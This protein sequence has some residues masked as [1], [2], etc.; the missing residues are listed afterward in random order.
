MDKKQLV[1]SFLLL[2]TATI[3]G[4]SYVAQSVV[5]SYL[6]AFSYSALKCAIGG[7]CLIPVCLLLYRQKGQKFKITKQE[8][9][10]GC[11][12]GI[13]LAIFCVLQQSGLATVE[14]GKASFIVA[15]YVILV[16]LLQALVSHKKP[17]LTIWL[18]ALLCVLGLYFVF[19][20]AELSIGKGEILL[21]FTALSSA[22]HIVYVG[23]HGLECR[24]L[25]ISMLQL[26]VCA[27]L[28]GVMAI[29]MENTSWDQIYQARY[30]LLY[31]GVLS[32][33]VGYSLQ[34][35]A[36][37]YVDPTLASLIMCLESVTALLFS[38]LILDQ[39]LSTTEFI[40][41][42]IIFVAIVIAQLSTN[43]KNKN[44]Q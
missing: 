25:V 12:L 42:C 11:V 30:S 36:Q 1:Y 10:T 29:F 35:I 31:T 28:C 16:P 44:H 37:K 43:K 3:W 23:E 32:A 21:L 41:C 27:V 33:G 19:G 14:A 38:W 24:G 22:I 5:T 26:L 34:I 6:G 20:F 18:C 17:S 9:N 4:G 40:G 7:I 8:R 39:G 13:I 2:L 15:L